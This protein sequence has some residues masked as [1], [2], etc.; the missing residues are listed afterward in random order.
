MQSDK[1]NKIAVFID[2]DNV[3]H[4]DIGC[5]MDEIRSNGVVIGK[6]VYG[7]F[8]KS[9]MIGWY[10]DGPKYGLQQMQCPR[11]SGKNSSDLKM[12]LDILEMVYINPEINL[13]YIITSDSDFVHVI[14]KL[15]FHNKRV[16]CIGRNN[17]NEALKSACDKF[18]RVE[19]LRGLDGPSDPIPEGIDEQA[20]I[21]QIERE[22]DLI[23]DNCGP[24]LHMSLINDHLINKMNFN[25][26]EFGRAS[27]TAFV[28]Q[29]FPQKYI[30]KKRDNGALFMWKNS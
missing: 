26:K 4:N 10:H 29:H 14:H 25:Y 15:K 22:I 6:F 20:K 23:L 11:L 2:G 8:S 7:D 17:A 28:N 3:S 21:N 1:I 30:I 16:N 9:E 18:I 12:S 24:I 19:V 27:F 5:V 13:Y